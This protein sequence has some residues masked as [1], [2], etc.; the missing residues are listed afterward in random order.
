MHY[1]LLGTFLSVINVVWRAI[2]TPSRAVC[3]QAS[4]CCLISVKL[5]AQNRPNLRILTH[6]RATRVSIDLDQGGMF[7][8]GSGESQSFTI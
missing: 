7:G 6:A 1:Q 3:F 8:Q 5:M 4:R 2:T